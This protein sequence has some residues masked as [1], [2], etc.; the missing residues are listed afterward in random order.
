MKTMPPPVKSRRLAEIRE[1]EALAAGEL[2]AAVFVR[3]DRGPVERAEQL[4]RIGREYDGPAA[5]GPVS[6]TVW[7]GDTV[8]AHAL[9]FGRTVRTDAGEL[10]VL[11]LAMVAADPQRRGQGLGAAI[12]RAAFA[13]IDSGEFPFS[14]FQTSHAVRPFYERHG[15]VVVENEIVNSLSETD[16]QAN[17]FWDEIVMRYPAGGDW[18]AGTIDLYGRG[19]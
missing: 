17:P 19:Y 2:L 10:P 14:L 7:D 16:P 18:P 8:V 6:H 5:Q 3:P 13:R 12:V 15:C 1:D 9:T 11:A 4:K